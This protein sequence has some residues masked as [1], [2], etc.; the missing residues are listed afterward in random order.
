MTKPKTKP[1][2]VTPRCPSCWGTPNEHLPCCALDSYQIRHFD[3]MKEDPRNE[4]EEDF[5][6][7]A[8]ENNGR[9]TI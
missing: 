6:R 4:P 3:A 7:R 8:A 5:Y 1:E 9:E 2:S